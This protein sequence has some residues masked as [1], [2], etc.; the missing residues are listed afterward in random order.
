[1]SGKVGKMVS[2]V[3]RALALAM[4]VAVIVL[5]ILNAAE[6]GTMVLLLGIGLLALAMASFQE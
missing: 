1:M 4:G 5:H 2:L 6:V 3:L